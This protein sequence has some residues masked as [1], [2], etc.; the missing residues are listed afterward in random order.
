MTAKGSL[1]IAGTS[2][3]V[4][5]TADTTVNGDQVRLK[6]VQKLKMT[7]FK[8]TPPSISI[9]V[10]SITCTDEIEI[11]YDVLFAPKGEARTEAK[12]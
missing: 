10:A 7:D 11:R 2:V 1:T 5:L 12:K 6:G 8:V 3:P 9:L 4:V